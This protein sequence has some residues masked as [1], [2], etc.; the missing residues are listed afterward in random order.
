MPIAAR[1]KLVVSRRVIRSPAL[2]GRRSTVRL[3]AAAE[4]SGASQPRPME[5]EPENDLQRGEPV[6]DAALE[7]DRARLFEVAR[8]HANLAD[9]HV[10]RDGLGHQLLVE[11]EV[12]AVQTIGDRLCLLYTS[13]SPRDRT[14][15]RMPS[16]A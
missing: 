4:L 12:V 16:S 6:D 10:D 7:V 11:D 9:P 8:R 13:P 3:L 5:H 2:G 14:R 1:A 15:S